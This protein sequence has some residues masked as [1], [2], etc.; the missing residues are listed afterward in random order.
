MVGEKNF[1]FLL[2][3]PEQISAAV[4]KELQNIQLGNQSYQEQATREQSGFV[5]AV[6]MRMG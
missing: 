5:R 2:L 6:A 4:W 3:L 1:L